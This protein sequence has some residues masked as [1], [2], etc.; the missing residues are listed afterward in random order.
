MQMNKFLE[1]INKRLNN[2]KN[3]NNNCPKL[4]EV[5]FELDELV[6]IAETQINKSNNGW[7]SVDDD[8]PKH[9]QEVLVCN[10]NSKHFNQV[11]IAIFEKNSPNSGFLVNGWLDEPKGKIT[12]WQP[13]PEPPKEQK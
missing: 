1:I 12:H 10:S 4:N 9:Q 2:Y 13:R 8:L 6:N 7:I 5:I 11:R 3:S